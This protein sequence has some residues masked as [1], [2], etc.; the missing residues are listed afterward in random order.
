MHKITQTHKGLKYNLNFSHNLTFFALM[1]SPLHA[2]TV[3]QAVHQN[4]SYLFII[5]YFLLTN[6]VAN[7]FLPGGF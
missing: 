6:S 1:L 7:F 3:S 5:E 4:G 2:D